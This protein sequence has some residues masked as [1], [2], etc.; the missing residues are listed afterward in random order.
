MK[1]NS[2]EVKLKIEK[3]LKQEPLNKRGYKFVGMGA[4]KVVLETPGSTRKIIK[5]S[6]AVLQQKITD[7]L[8]NQNNSSNSIDNQNHD[9]QRSGIDEI[10][11]NEKELREIFGEEH[12]LKTGVFKIKIPITKEFLISF[13]G[14]KEKHLVEKLTDDFESE[15]EMLAETQLIAEELK[16]PKKF[17][18][19]D[20]SVD[21][22]THKKFFGEKN[23]EDA[24]TRARGFVDREFLTTFKKLSEDEKYKNVIKEIVS[25]IIEYTKKTGLIVDIFGKNNITIYEKENG[26][27]DYHIIEALLPGSKESWAKNISQD[28]QLHLLRH[29]YVYYYTIKNIAEIIGI[30]DNIKPEDLIYFKNSAIPTGN[31]PSKNS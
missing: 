16:N 29:Y 30:E 11:E 1:E 13:V 24:L 12:F 21:I 22:I 26:V 19:K 7:L 3:I 17:R 14:N 8:I 4:D 20:F 15:I 5:V 25:K 28:P 10:A 9:I 18:P 6:R 27:V 23:I 2:G 31:W